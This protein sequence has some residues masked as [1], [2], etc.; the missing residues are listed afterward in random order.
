M[1]SAIKLSA[2]LILTFT[3]VPALSQ[4]Q[5]SISLPDSLWNSTDTVVWERKVPNYCE[6]P[7]YEAATGAVYF[8][9]QTASQP[10]WPIMRTVP[11]VD[12][13]GVWYNT[14]QS[15]GLA[16]DRQ[17]RLV[18]CQNGQV[19]RL[20]SNGTSGVLD[21][22]LTSGFGNTVQSNDLAIGKNG[23]IYFSGYS[24]NN[25]YY[26][27]TEGVRTTVATGVSSSNWIEWLQDLDS[28]ALYVNSSGSGKVYRYVRDPA[29]GALSGR[30]DFITV[31]Q[32]DGGTYDS[33]G[34]RYVASYG[35]GEI[36]VYNNAATYLGRIALRKQSGI[37]D[38]VA[39]QG[40]KGKQGNAD[41]C[42]FGGP[43]MKT[44][45]ITGDGG[46]FSL[47]LKV[48]GVPA[49]PVALRPMISR[50]TKLRGENENRDVRGRL[51]APSSKMPAVKVPIPE[52][53]R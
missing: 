38:S 46:L 9:V 41:N 5:D 14:K 4:V 44:L 39:S 27:N 53:G 12:T 8:T 30:T 1:Y 16:F 47:R 26:L 23:D 29:T 50:E 48:A 31:T 28:N 22:I 24:D 43:D 52:T 37:Y 19:V 32:P 49:S 33:H 21:T 42:V 25:V 20:K 3:A 18:A 17:G 35:N 34:N 45:Y 36:R 15:N 7:A 51:L 11:G 2:V 40:R 6:G 13:G 10:N